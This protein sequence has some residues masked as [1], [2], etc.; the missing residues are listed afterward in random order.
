MVNDKQ[1]RF[2]REYVIDFNATQAAIR[3]GYSKRSSSTHGYRLLKNDEIQTRIKEI[4]QDAVDRVSLRQD[5]VL[6][7][8]ARVA[9]ADIRKLF[10][11][12]GT[13]IPIADLPEEV[14]AALGSVDIQTS[15]DDV[16]VTT[17]KIRMADKLKALEQ[18][19][20]YFKLFTDQVEVTAP[21]PI[22]GVPLSPEQWEAMYGAGHVVTQ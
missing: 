16:P 2:C 14:A 12:D 6:E 17:T 19:G 1:E 9:F 7:E 5:R 22:M 3:A 10:N 4:A 21:K 18:L 13:L 15:D 8:I 11:A 20:R